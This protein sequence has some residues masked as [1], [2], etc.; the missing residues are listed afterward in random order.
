[1]Y[2][3][4]VQTILQGSKVQLMMAQWEVL[5]RILQFPKTVI[6]PVSGECLSW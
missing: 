4:S 1:M 5:N 3:H 6:V 2:L